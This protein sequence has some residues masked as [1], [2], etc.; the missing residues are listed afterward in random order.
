MLKYK[1]FKKLIA[2][3]LIVIYC[4]TAL[5]NIACAVDTTNKYTNEQEIIREVADAYYSKGTKAQY[6]SY[7]KSFIDSPEEAT[8]QHTIYNVCSNYAYSIYYQAFGIRIP[9]LTTTMIPYAQKYYDSDNIV[10]NDIIEYWQVTTDEKGNKTY[11][12][13]KGNKKDINLSTGTGR[14]SYATKLLTDYNLQVG[15]IIC[16]FVEGTGGHAVVIYDII[17]DEDGQPIDALIRESV[18]KYDTTTTKITKGLSYAELINENN[19]IYE[20]SLQER[21]LLQTY[22]SSTER[23]RRSIMV[24][25]QY[26]SYFTVM[27]PLLKDKNGNYIGKYYYSTFQSADTTLGYECIDRTLTGYEITEA[28]NQRVK[29]SG[30][31]IEKQLMYLII[32]LL[33]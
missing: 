19:N 28:S 26:A 5:S 9:F 17:Y 14:K 11:E 23:K 16:Y 2:S 12:D 31:D 24:A 29:Y 15:D 30:I 7:R 4:I 18:S 8:S 6:C 21:Y 25:T 10:T 33:I 27:R 20:G 13:N 22:E 3:W 1:F 32:V